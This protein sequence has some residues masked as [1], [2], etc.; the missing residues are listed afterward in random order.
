MKEY[1]FKKIKALKQTIEEKEFE[2][3]KIRRDII[4][5]TELLKGLEGQVIDNGYQE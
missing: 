3:I 5:L 2:I 4:Y 1:E